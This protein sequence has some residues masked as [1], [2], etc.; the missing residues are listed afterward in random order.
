MIKKGDRVKMN[1]KYFVTEKNKEKVF[2][3]ITDV[4]DMCGCKVVWLKGY[5]GCYAADGLEIV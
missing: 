3:V 1:N 5:N 2:I 4:Q